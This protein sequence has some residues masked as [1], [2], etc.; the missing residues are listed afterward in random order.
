[1]NMSTILRT[2]AVILDDFGPSATDPIMA[3]VNELYATTEPTAV[4]DADLTDRVLADIARPVVH[5]DLRAT[6]AIGWWRELCSRLGRD[7]ADAAI[8]DIAD[9]TECNSGTS[10]PCLT[11]SG[12]VRRPHGVR[13][14]A[15]FR[16]TKG[17]LPRPRHSETI[18]F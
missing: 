13:I 1:M 16:E 17:S 11:K 12:K 15:A 10:A 18:E 2:A 7:D 14:T 3:M 6:T 5:E 4:L 9:C 8:F